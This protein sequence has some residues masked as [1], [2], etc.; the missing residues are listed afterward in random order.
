MFAGCES[1]LQVSLCP[2][3]VLMNTRSPVDEAEYR[4]PFADWDSQSSVRSQRSPLEGR[5]AVSDIFPDALVPFFS[6]PTL[7]ALPE[8]IKVKIRE[9]HLLRYLNFTLALETDVVNPVALD[10][11]RRRDGLVLP[12]QMRIDAYRIYC[13]EAYHALFTA[14]II[15]QLSTTNRSLNRL[16]ESPYF[17]VGLR[18]LMSRDENF[19]IAE[20]IRY[21]FVIISEMLITGTL[22]DFSSESSTTGSVGQAVSLHARDETKH[23]VFFT[24][25][26]EI[27]LAAHSRATAQ[28]L[29]LLVPDLIRCFLTP[30]PDELVQELESY[31]LDEEMSREEVRIVYSG[32]R[33]KEQRRRAARP[34][35]SALRRL[36]YLSQESLVERFVNF[37]LMKVGE[38][39]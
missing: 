39:T 36:G 33:A 31:G 10:I 24:Q 16:D 22:R 7:K 35:V 8:R 30:G 17:A 20:E 1:S 3:R 37:D 14:Q 34:I 27:F 15:E 28:R 9:R 11:A 29:A 12:P 32:E 38:K 6:S 13:D 18:R 5:A 25:Y 4:T 21:L 2:K 26:M 19:D 23:H